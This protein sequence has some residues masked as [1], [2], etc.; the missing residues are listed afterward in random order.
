[1]KHSFQAF[2]IA[3]HP[4]PA[5]IPT[6][7]LPG[8]LE[9][10]NYAPIK[11]HPRA[12]YQD[13]KN[14]PLRMSDPRIPELYPRSTPSWQGKQRQAFWDLNEGRYQP[15]NTRPDLLE[16]K[17][18]ECLSRNGRLYAESVC[19]PLL[20]LSPFPL[21]SF[22]LPPSS[23]PLGPCKEATAANPTVSTRMQASRTHTPRTVQPSTRTASS[24][25]S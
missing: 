7:Y 1:M 17:A 20:V 24:R 5:S 16:K 19:L 18:N 8:I 12:T 13:L 9:V 4:L 25:G 23:Y 15:F 6:T 14:R 10:P 11:R 22:P 21:T 3:K 2:S